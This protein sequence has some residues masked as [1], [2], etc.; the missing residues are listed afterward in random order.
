M[1]ARQ[2]CPGGGSLPDEVVLKQ[3][4]CSQNSHFQTVFTANGLPAPVRYQ[5]GGPHRTWSRQSILQRGSVTLALPTLLKFGKPET[6]VAQMNLKNDIPTH[7]GL[8]TRPRRPMLKDPVASGSSL[9]APSDRSLILPES[10][11]PYRLNCQRALSYLAFVGF[12]PPSAHWP[13]EATNT[14]FTSPGCAA[15]SGFL[16]LSV[17][18]SSL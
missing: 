15:L 1:I 2:P 5:P 6:P 16:N 17:R 8:E 14:G 10:T 12:L 13:E 4:P 11:N 7:P 3:E 18:Y 9:Q